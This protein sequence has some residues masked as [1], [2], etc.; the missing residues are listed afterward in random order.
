MAVHSSVLAWEISWTEEPDG[1][2]F[3]GLQR[4]RPELAPKQQPNKLTIKLNSVFPIYSPPMLLKRR[5]AYLNMSG[6]FTKS[7][8]HSNLRRPAVETSVTTVKATQTYNNEP[9]TSFINTIR[10]IQ[11]RDTT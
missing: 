9:D 8:Q 3:M 11:D 7:S 10:E 2:Q 5:T 1:L 4:V 6:S